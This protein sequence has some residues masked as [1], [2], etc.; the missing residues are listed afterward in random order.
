MADGAGGR[1]LA[2]R[3]SWWYGISSCLLVAVVTG[4]L[5]VAL[6]RNFDQQNERYLAQKV[7]I[8]RTLLEQSGDQAATVKW[9]VEEEQTAHT[10]IHV[11][12][13][14][15]SVDGTRLYETTGMSGELPASVV[16]DRNGAEVRSRSGRVYR[17]AQVSVPAKDRVFEI[18]AAIDLGY[19]KDLLTRYQNQLWIAVAFGF[20]VAL[21]VGHR[22]AH[23]G[24]QPVK[25]M[26]AAVKEISSHNL[27]ERIRLEHAP[28]EL[29]ALCE[30]FNQTLDRLQDAF[31]RLS[32]FSSDIAHELRT[33]INNVRGELE[34]A[35]SHSR[36]T[37]QY[38]EAIGSALEECERVSRLIESLLFL[39]RAEHPETGVH[40]EPLH[41][42]S[43]LAKLMLF[44]EAPAHERGITV[45]ARVPDDLYALLDRNLL[46]RALG[47]LIENAFRHTPRGGTVTLGARREG[48]RLF[49]TVSD[50]GPG[51]PKAH[52]ARIF[53]RFYRVDEARTPAEGGAGLGL[54]IVKSIAHLHG[55]EVHVDTAE[56]RGTSITMAFELT[57]T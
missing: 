39:A 18:Q 51:I 3:L 31:G 9:E 16:A 36:S 28:S 46:Q 27:G 33:P 54:A 21:F 8:L 44:Y 29:A 10:S 25:F 6:L 40:R 53:D 41:L 15:L 7:S 52:V 13:R 49:L 24:I 42:S 43:E 30:T 57:K 34:V 11:L 14:I 32:Q 48:E 45:E 1:S 12:S 56:G 2:V 38:R 22:I 20:A 50:T 35:L 37:A 23:T 19:Q 47:N 55:G 5:Y 17:V 4:L 26:A